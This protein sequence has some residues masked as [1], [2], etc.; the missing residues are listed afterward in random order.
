MH[1]HRKML[2]A[3]RVVAA[4][5]LALFGYL[6]A[7]A[8][9]TEHPPITARF[10]FLATVAL[11]LGATAIRLLGDASA[12]DRIERR[13]SGHVEGVRETVDRL[14]AALPKGQSGQ[15]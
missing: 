3:G 5:S 2:I 14:A 11:L 12:V 13:T 4:A 15:R 6:A 10:V 8:F 1:H 9:G 7:V